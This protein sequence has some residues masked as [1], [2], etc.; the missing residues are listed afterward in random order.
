[1]IPG[2]WPWSKNKTCK[3]LGRN[4]QCIA[5]DSTTSIHVVKTYHIMSRDAPLWR[6]G[7]WTLFTCGRESWKQK[8][9]KKALHLVGLEP[10]I[11]N[12]QAGALSNLTQPTS[13]ATKVKFCNTSWLFYLR[14]PIKIKNLDSFTSCKSLM[15][16][17]P[18]N[19]HHHWKVFYNSINF[20]QKFIL[21]NSSV[22]QIGSVNKSLNFRVNCAKTFCANLDQAYTIPPQ[23]FAHECATNCHHVNG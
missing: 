10:S 13:L 4:H 11:T 1:M 22:L 23:S 8:K 17:F 15:S 21:P 9:K 16:T 18:F 12:Y 20:E 7:L 19:R 6:I 14:D 5:L 2:W 3:P